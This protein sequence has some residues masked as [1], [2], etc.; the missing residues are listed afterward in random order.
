M[1][2]GRICVIREILLE[3]WQE[4]LV[5]KLGNDFRVRESGGA[6]RLLKR[7]KVFLW[8]RTPQTGW[9]EVAYVAT[10]DAENLHKAL[11]PVLTALTEQD[12]ERLQAKLDKEPVTDQWRLEV[13]EDETI[14][15]KK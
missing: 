1:K 10:E 14:P 5:K 2:R 4:R 15:P 12:K 7:C 9:V 11:N 6:F 8:S 13:A 3:T